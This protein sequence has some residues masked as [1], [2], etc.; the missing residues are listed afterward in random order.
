MQV[1]LWY[2]PK[3]LFFCVGTLINSYWVLTAG[4]CILEVKNNPQALL[5]IAGTSHIRKEGKQWSGC[6]QI[7]EHDS[8]VVYNR[9]PEETYAE[10]D[11][12]LL[13]V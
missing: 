5:I 1:Q 10:N 8:F 11:I 13:R 7:I 12:A 3:S 2:A 4:H 6:S 9:T